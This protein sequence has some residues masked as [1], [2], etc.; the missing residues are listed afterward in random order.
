MRV[1][2][3]PVLAA[4][5]LAL[6]VSLPS[7]GCAGASQGQ[8]SGVDGAEV[9]SVAV[10]PLAGTPDASPLSEISFRGIAPGELTG[11][12]VVGS[13]SGP[14]TGKLEAHSDGQGVSFVPYRKFA[15]G[16]TVDVQA[17]QP[18]AGQTSG[19]V[20]FRIERPAGGLSPRKTFPDGSDP[21]VHGTNHYVSRP[22]L[23][24]PRMRVK[25]SK[26]GAS[27]DYIFMAP[28]SWPG[29]DGPMILDSKGRIVWFHKL[30][31]A[32]K[33]YD[34]RTATYEGKPVLTWWQGAASG[35]YG[36][37]TGII[38]DSSYKVIA[39]VKG[40][41]GYPPDIHE[42]RVTPQGTAL[43]VAYQPVR[44]NTRAFGGEKNGAILD[45]IA[46]EIDIKTGRVLF[47]WHSL[48]HIGVT[49]SH[50]LF[51]KG[52]PVDYTHLN[53]V[54]LDTDGNFLI[55][56]RNTW[57]VYKVDRETGEVIWR[58]GG[59]H[60]SFQLPGYATFVGQ[61]DF[62]RASNGDYTLFDNHNI[63]A[64]PKWVSRGMV[65]SIDADSHTARLLHAFPHPKGAGTTTQGSVQVLPSGNYVVGWGGGIPEISEFSPGGR[66]LF[67][68]T[69]VAKVQSYRV[70]RF[71][72]SGRPNRP[73]DV[74][75]RS[76]KRRTVAFASWN[77]ATDVSSWT[78]L[79]GSNA[80]DLSV[81]AHGRSKGF[82]T[83]IP[84]PGPERYVAVQA[85]DDSGT[86]L[87]KSKTVRARR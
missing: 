4:L 40:G 44:G 2:G 46:M 24:P 11:V 69:L 27:T 31:R 21:T 18:L 29:Q 8:A 70:Y 47:E 76:V 79:A 72:W 7:L 66:L 19:V 59:R 54:A 57:A 56:A 16:E 84:L 60:S 65:F 3:K 83:P 63:I 41:N 15:F 71:P 38:A 26:P 37:G 61:H 48:G 9:Q 62:K 35:E 67:D 86:V 6:A 34:F 43:I 39:T 32:F 22:D 87:A 75:V 10:Y 81:V 73:P 14:H 77:G 68:A 1:R 49:E 5:V 33:A 50:S 25:L 23:H 74:R 82:E 20:S 17:D 64:P 52:E 42:F 51:N 30:R 12:K 58:L 13:K 28:K 45:S 36:G 55:S 80:S 85:V 53:S 78:V